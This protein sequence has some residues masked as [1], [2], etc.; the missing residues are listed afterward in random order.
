MQPFKFVVADLWTQ[1]P[2]VSVIVCV[3]LDDNRFLTVG[4]TPI[5]EP[6]ETAVINDTLVILLKL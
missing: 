2:E 6:L 5:I 4:T 3:Q 1:L